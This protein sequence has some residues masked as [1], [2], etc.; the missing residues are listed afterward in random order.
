[1]P[2]YYTTYG[3]LLAFKSN[4]LYNLSSEVLCQQSSITKPR[5]GAN[6][7]AKKK[8]AKKA[9]AKKTAKKKK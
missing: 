1:L 2:K 9:P 7:P 3:I 5:K 4:I 6:M 8:A